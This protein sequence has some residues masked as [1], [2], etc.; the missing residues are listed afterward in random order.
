MNTK[1]AKELQIN[2]TIIFNHFAHTIKEIKETKCYVT[3]I[4]QDNTK[5]R[6]GKNTE[7]LIKEVKEVKE[8]TEIKE[9]KEVKQTE[10]VNLS[11]EI[12]DIKEIK[13]NKNNSYFIDRVKRN[14][15]KTH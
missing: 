4:F 6:Y 7:V 9:I 1:Q 3:F 2:D 11:E 8:V 10:E 14:K 5:K 13:E 12:T 15:K